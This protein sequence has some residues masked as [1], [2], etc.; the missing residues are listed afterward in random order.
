M[1]CGREIL[2][3]LMISCLTLKMSRTTSSDLPEKISFSSASS[4]LPILRSIG[5]Q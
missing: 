3:K 5:K 1:R 2:R 4:L